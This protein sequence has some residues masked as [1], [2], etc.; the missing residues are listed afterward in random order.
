ML[1]CIASMKGGVGKSTLAAM[2][3]KHVASSMAIPVTV[4][5][6][7][8]QRGATILLLGPKKAAAHIGPT[9][10]DV[11]K[12]EWDNMPSQEILAQA[13]VPASYH[14]GVRLVPAAAALARLV[15]PGTSQDLMRLAYIQR[16]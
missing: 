8:P 5:D 1:V 7:D 12:S 4:V 6:M 14:E 2:L 13:I 10:Y 3:A 11:L 15:I 9:M 16:Y